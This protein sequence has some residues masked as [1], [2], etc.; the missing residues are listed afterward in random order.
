MSK[1]H[2]PHRAPWREKLDNFVM[3]PKVQYFL[4]LLI[5]A[6]AALMGLETSSY[7][8]EHFSREL[9]M[10]DEAILLVFIVEIV[11]LLLARGLAFFKD[12]WSVFDFIV[13]SIAVVPATESFSVLRA[14]R[15]LR[16]LRLFTKVKSLQKVVKS[17][18]SAVPGLG[19]VGMVM[20][21]IFYVSAVL[22]TNLFSKDFPET[23]G[24]MGLT[25]YTLFQ[26]MTGDGWSDSVARPV[27]EVFP[28]AWIFFIIFILISTFV[29]LNLFI[30][31]IVDASNDEAEAAAKAERRILRTHLEEMRKELTDFRQRFDDIEAQKN[32]N[33]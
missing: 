3:A 20:L 25:L 13:I 19:S 30:A 22:A 23:F 16:V 4:I 5:L 1:A 27:M 10:L 31:V 28:Y 24:N 18:L 32:R 17:L 2:H 9:V 33:V 6:N 14:L 11:C 12:P 26:I 29:I 21:L 15:V 7:V 8:Q